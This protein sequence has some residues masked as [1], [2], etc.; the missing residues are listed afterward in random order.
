MYST[1]SADTEVITLI[2]IFDV[3][4]ERQDDL[5]EVLDSATVEVMRRIPGFV[6]ANI[7]ASLDRT[8]V[9][10]YAQWRSISDFEAMLGREDVKPHMAKAS[11]LATANPKLY[12]VKSVHHVD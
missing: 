4:P 9:V 7:H 11:E 3:D 1:I 6:S 10:N 5:I 12:Q 2:N 8:R